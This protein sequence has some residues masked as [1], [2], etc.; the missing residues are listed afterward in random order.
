VRG[1]WLHTTP[2]RPSV[3]IGGPGRAG[4][5]VWAGFNGAEHGHAGAA[6]RA[7]CEVRGVALLAGP[8]NFKG[9]RIEVKWIAVLL[10]GEIQQKNLWAS[11]PK[12]APL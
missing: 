1:N 11:M 7:K 8:G 12:L 4:G 10:R 2:F 9:E 5:I 6:R 3:P